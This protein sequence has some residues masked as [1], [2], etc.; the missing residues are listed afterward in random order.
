[1]SSNL[2]ASRQLSIMMIITVLTQIL[3]LW[4]SS[5]I[6]SKFGVGIEMDS[7]NFSMSIMGMIFG[8]ISA[9]I[10]SILI[11]NLIKS[12]FGKS[13]NSFITMI[14]LVSLGLVVINII[15]GK[16]I[17]IILSGNKNQTFINF[18]NRIVPIVSI[19]SFLGIICAIQNSILQAKNIFNIP[20]V[21]TLVTSLILIISFMIIPKNEIINYVYMLL[22]ISIIT[23]IL[24]Y[25]ST[26]DIDYKYEFKII[27]ND[28]NYINMKKGFIPVIL[29]SAFYQ[30]SLLIDNMISTRL[31]EGQISILNYSNVIVSMINV[32]FLGNITTFLYPKLARI[33][34]EED[35]KENLFKYITLIN[36]IMY[37]LVIGFIMVGKQAIELIY[38][39]GSID[40]EITNI[41]YICCVIYIISL[42]V[43]ATKDLIYKYFFIKGD[44]RTPFINS[45]TVSTIN[46]ILSIIL[47]RY[48]GLYGVVLG[49]VIA[50]FI[51]LLMI[52]I[53]L[54]LKSGLPKNYK[55]S[56]K[57]NFIIIISAINTLLINII[58]E[59]KIIINNYIIY[60]LTFGIITF[61]TYLILTF[62]F[63]RD[64]FKISIS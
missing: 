42:P 31:G 64:I 8:F 30:V 9:G 11:P 17:I 41:I 63:N 25:I 61:V 53:K 36:M 57:M 18:S 47:C 59:R 50:N 54:Y 56:L 29:S 44:T 35:L 7:L 1:M 32:M 55:Q 10:S 52:I 14:I 3:S 24:I 6:A 2:K 33:Y 62:I 51:S 16:Y 40:S 26:K 22:L 49:T 28:T 13:V 21:I 60:I 23:F 5:L 45:V 20:K 46:I 4:K 38:K 58:L 37:L 39:H 19:T 12:E 15:F 43:N 27:K 48:I 34:N